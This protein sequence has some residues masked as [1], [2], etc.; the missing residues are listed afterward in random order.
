MTGKKLLLLAATFLLVGCDHVSKEVAKSALEG[1]PPRRLLGPL[2]DLRYTENRDVAFELLRWVPGGVRGPLL[3]VCGAV[4]LGVLVTVLLRRRVFD[5][6]TA[7]LLLLLA[8]AAGNYADRLLRGYVVDFIH[9]PHWPVFNVADAYV[10]AGIALLLLFRPR[11][12]AVAAG[13]REGRAG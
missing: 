3:L 5:G 7:A 6:V 8:G 1:E 2:L 9:V 4:A 10:V 11:A 13:L 12:P